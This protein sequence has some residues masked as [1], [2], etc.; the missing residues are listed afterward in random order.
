MFNITAPLGISLFSFVFEAAG[1]SWRN[2]NR[3]V[4]GAVYQ[5]LD[6]YVV[7]LASDLRRSQPSCPATRLVEHAEAS[8][9]QGNH[10]CALHSE[11]GNYR[12]FFSLAAFRKA[13]EVATPSKIRFLPVGPLAA[14]SALVFALNGSR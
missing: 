14:D 13:A 10:A 3:G 7:S 8:G 5:I 9:A 12:Q 1:N 11:G 2:C 6:Y 4:T